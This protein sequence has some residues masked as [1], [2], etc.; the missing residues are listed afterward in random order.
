MIQGRHRTNSKL[1]PT[2]FCDRVQI[3]LGFPL[4]PDGKS[5]QSTTQVTGVMTISTILFHTTKNFSICSRLD[6]ENPSLL[7]VFLKAIMPLPPRHILSKSTFLMGCQ[8]PKRLWLHKFQPDVRDEM[9]EGQEAI[10]QAGTDVGLI[11]RQ[12]FDEGI[13][14]S[15]P[16]FYQYQKSVAD[17]EKYIRN[18][19]NIIYEACFQFDGVLS[20][21][22]ILVKKRNKWYAFEVKGS[23]SV[24][25]Q[26]ILDAAIQYYVIT[27]SG[28]QL[29]DISIV[30][31]DTDYIRQGNLDIQKLFRNTSILKKVEGLQPAIAKKTIELKNV[32]Q[33]KTSP[34]VKMGDHCSKPYQC[35]FYGFCSKD[36]I[37]DEEEEPEYI[38]RVAISDFVK[39]LQYPL[40]FLDFET[41]MTA[42]PEQDGHW[43]F[44]QIPFQYSLHIQNDKDSPLDH[45]Y[46]LA[47][48]PH[49]RHIEFIEHLLTSVEQKGT[50]LVYN[51]TFENT[52]LNH[53]KDEFTQLSD[54]IEKIQ[55]RM[56]DLMT[57]FRK[58]YRLPAMK[59]SYSIKYV[60]PALVPELNYDSLTIG[61]GSDASAAFYNLKHNT[62]ISERMSTRKTLLDYCG[63]DTLAMVKILEKIMSV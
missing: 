16:T 51:K 4:S 60:L 28:L 18:G 2:K 20:A 49:T 27:N 22:D 23:A 13:D 8:C 7:F 35:D 14:A 30:H 17:T 29:E 39:Q 53:L 21:I 47:D 25:P 63:L 59:G 41:W 61:N 37:E 12:L 9:D 42:V 52:I 38:N 1:L 10:F 5:F 54:D 34:D 6:Q 50:V 57:P 55:N 46:Y 58:N 56:I 62:D 40:Q 44:R 19:A 48:G 15:P 33:M 24:K 36:I 11:A 26:F 3:Q 31:L 32:L 45:R 43:P